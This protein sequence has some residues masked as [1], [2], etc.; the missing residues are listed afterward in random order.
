MHSAARADAQ[1]AKHA[2]EQLARKRAPWSIDGS[3][4]GGSAHG[5]AWHSSKQRNGAVAT[6]VSRWKGARR[7]PQTLRLTGSRGSVGKRRSGNG[8]TRHEWSE[9]SSRTVA[10]TCML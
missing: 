5:A 9:L 6:A 10:R 8:G 4:A 7:V 3:G 1:L 2:R